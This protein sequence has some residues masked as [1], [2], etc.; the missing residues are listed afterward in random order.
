M[1]TSRPVTHRA[2]G[3][4]RREALLE[5]AV[6]IVAERGVGGA[7][8]R[9]IAQ[10]AGVPP[11]TT[12]YFFSSIDELIVA[13]IQRF[14]QQRVEQFTAMAALLGEQQRTPQEVATL[15]AQA[16]TTAPLPQEIAQFEA[17]LDAGRREPDAPRPIADVLR[18]FEGVAIAALQAMGIENPAA[19]APAFVAVA[20]GYSVRRIALGEQPDVAQVADIFLRLL[21]SFAAKPG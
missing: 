4:A 9:A 13:A 12:T 5:A 3:L 1:P 16:L 8:H 21:D 11:S 7:T 14:T 15:F 10:R 19:A 18:A 6:E 20:D 2:R 17:Y